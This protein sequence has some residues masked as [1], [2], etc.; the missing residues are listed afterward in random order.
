MDI[1]VIMSLFHITK[2]NLSANVSKQRF[3]T[4]SLKHSNKQT[5]FIHFD[6]ISHKSMKQEST[7]TKY[8]TL[9]ME[10]KSQ[11]FIIITIN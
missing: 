5:Q 8:N 10:K 7:Y 6:N 4:L 11:I 9:L 2:I 1:L 3:V